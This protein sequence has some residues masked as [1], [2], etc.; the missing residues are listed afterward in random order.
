[1]KPHALHV[2]LSDREALERIAH[3]DYQDI[4]GEAGDLTI[5]DQM[6]ADARAALKGHRP[7]GCTCSHD[8]GDPGPNVFIQRSPTCPIHGWSE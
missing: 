4:I 7:L 6:R 3:H 8:P 1:M 5:A 2:P